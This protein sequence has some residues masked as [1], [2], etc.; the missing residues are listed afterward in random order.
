MSM[1]GCLVIIAAGAI[2]HATAH[3]LNS[4]TGPHDYLHLKQHQ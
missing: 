2:W 3:C 4:L 1:L